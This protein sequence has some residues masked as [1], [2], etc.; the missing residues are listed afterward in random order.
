MNA[1]TSRARVSRRA[2]PAAS[3]IRSKMILLH[4]LFSLVLAAVLLLVLRGPV[5]TLARDAEIRQCTLGMEVV[6]KT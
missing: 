5:E 6:P 2:T 1:P 3:R 4:T